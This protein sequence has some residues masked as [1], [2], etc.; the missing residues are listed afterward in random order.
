VTLFIPSFYP[1][2]PPTIRVTPTDQMQIS[3]N[4]QGVSVSTGEV[5]AEL[6]AWEQTARLSTVLAKC[7]RHFS[8][9]M[10]VFAR[11]PRATGAGRAERQRRETGERDRRGGGAEGLPPIASGGGQA[12]LALLHKVQAEAVEDSKCD[13]DRACVVCLGNARNQL[14]LPCRHMQVCHTCTIGILKQP[15]P[16]CPVCRAPIQDVMT[17]FS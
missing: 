16:Q 17:V 13:D 3:P 15:E 9:H 7:Q 10:P 5:S 2:R 6:L 12:R 4:S 11:P 14:Y 1:H 8:T